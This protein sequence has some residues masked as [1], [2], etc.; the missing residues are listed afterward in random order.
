MK[1]RQPDEHQRDGKKG[2]HGDEPPLFTSASV[3]S[4]LGTSRSLRRLM[5]REMRL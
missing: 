1:E 4:Y 3:S 2:E 5:A